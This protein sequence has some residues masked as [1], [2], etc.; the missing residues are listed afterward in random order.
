M[1][2]LISPAKTLDFSKS[3]LDNHTQ[4]R[5]LKDSKVL[6]KELRQHNVGD[7]RKLMKVS[8][9]IATLN[10]A[11]YKGFKTPFTMENAKQA[12]LAFKGDV[13]TGLEAETFTQ[14][15]FEFAQQHL[16]ILSGL[17][18]LLRPLDLMQPYR[19]EMGTKLENER[20]KNLYQFWDNK[21]TKL[22]NKDLK[23]SN[24]KVIINLASNE[25]F[26]SVQ[27]KDLKG[28]LYN[29]VFKDE[30]NGVFKVIA[31]FAKKAR[32]MMCQYVIKNQCVKPEE[33]KNFDLGG[34][35]FNENMS[36]EREYVFTREA[37]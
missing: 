22:I 10:V 15:D 24:S 2:L 34:Y 25:Y 21:I 35:V 18:G 14:K 9:N 8:D 19:L 32:G 17:Y 4:A 36:S 26:K 13:Y 30:K 11:R 16:R 6:I 3:E 31:F 29:I 37:Q 27:K 23:A 28:D 20:G 7:I 5:L 33:L 1:I 12:I